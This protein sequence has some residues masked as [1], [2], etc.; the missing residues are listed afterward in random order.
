MNSWIKNHWRKLFTPQK[1]ALT[2]HTSPEK[3]QAFE[4][5]MLIAGLYGVDFGN[6]D[7]DWLRN[8]RSR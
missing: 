7:P 2:E 8:V 4:S 1:L 6:F 3:E 5:M